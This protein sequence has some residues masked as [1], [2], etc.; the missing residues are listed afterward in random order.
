MKVLL[1]V[2]IQNDFCPGGALAVPE[3]HQ[4]VA[5]ANGLM[6]SGEFD[7]VVASL[8]WHPADHVSF[9]SN[10]S[11]RSPF[12]SIMLPGGEQTLWPAHCVQGTPGA[13]LHPDLDRSR[14]NAF[15]TKGVDRQVD[16]YSAFFDNDRRRETPLRQLLLAKAAL[17]G[18]PDLNEIQLTL[19]GLATDY[20][21]AATARDAL[22][23]SIST[24]LVLDA[25][26]A[27]NLVPGDEERVLRDLA[28]R[29]ASIVESREILG[30]ANRDR[31]VERPIR[32]PSIYRSL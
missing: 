8:D 13:D 20:C 29:G 12:E 2:D 14:I 5:V 25:C 15:V 31:I 4:V 6:R 11:G 16:S 21:V 18:T 17:F 22:D 30:D 1:L 23:L 28:R 26:R 27:V 19:C 9:A 24:T 7:L 10:H 3:G 32:E